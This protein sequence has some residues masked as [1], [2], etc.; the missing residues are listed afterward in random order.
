ME[1]NCLKEMAPII[2]QDE[3]VGIV[4]PKFINYFSR[5]I[6]SSGTWVSRSFYSGHYVDKKERQK[7]KE[8]PYLGIEMVRT[9]LVKRLGHIYDPDY[10]IYAEDLDLSLCLRLLGMTT[11]YVPKAKIYHMHAATT[12]KSRSSMMTFLME[13]NL[14]ITFFKV[15]SLRNLFLFLP[16][17]LL[18]R[19]LAVAKDILS[20]RPSSAFARLRAYLWVIG[21]FPLVMKKRKTLQKM[22]TVDDGFLL[23]VF[24]EK[25][26]FKRKTLL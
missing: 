21:H 13:R 7:V 1:R 14:L 19:A 6:E 17:V 20:L 4:V 3:R 5:S 2:E 11:V 16:Y 12:K 15:L 18:I 22:R 24:S 10:F 9:S 8:I 23:K 25:H 26:L